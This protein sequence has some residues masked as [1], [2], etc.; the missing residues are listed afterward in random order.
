MLRFLKRFCSQYARRMLVFG[1]L[2]GALEPVMAMSSCK[3]IFK[4]KLPFLGTRSRATF[5]KKFSDY[6]AAAKYKTDVR[7]AYFDVDSTLRVSLS[8]APWATHNRDVFI[9]PG[10]ADAIA[11]L[12]KSNYVIV[13]FSNQGGNII[14]RYGYE[15]VDEAMKHTM[16]LLEELNPG[17]IVDYYDFAEK[18]DDMRK[19]DLGMHH[20]LEKKMLESGVKI[21]R[22]SHIYI[23]DSLYTTQETDAYGFSGQDFS[24]VDRLFVENLKREGLGVDLFHP[25]LAFNWTSRVRDI[26]SGVYR[27]AHGNKADAIEL[28]TREQADLRGIRLEDPFRDFRQKVAATDFG[29]PKL[30]VFESLG[31]EAI[32]EKR[33][34]QVFR[35]LDD[36]QS[37]FKPEQTYT[38]IAFE[39]AFVKKDDDQLPEKFSPILVLGKNILGY[40]HVVGDFNRSHSEMDTIPVK[41]IEDV[42]DVPV[43]YKLVVRKSYGYRGSLQ[44]LA[45]GSIVVS[46]F[47]GQ[48]EN[49][50][51]AWKIKEFLLHFTPRDIFINAIAGRLRPKNQ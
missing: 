15:A 16:D 10:A 32:D 6:H 51:V 19:P 22:Y 2:V 31:L 23:G 39:Y 50:I 3:E 45:N 48:S 7:I 49:A 26:V 34:R 33:N 11:E 27:L 4:Y 25:S 20:R 12:R 24:N 46:G 36:L 18:H 41:L 42:F 30:L 21:A 5:S 43:G 8:G 13:L 1:A 40:R 29:V 38:T 35:R 9:L 14:S 17:A 44:F 28:A 37:E 47:S